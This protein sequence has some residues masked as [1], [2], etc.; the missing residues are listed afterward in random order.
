LAAFFISGWTDK[1]NNKL[2]IA[3][4]ELVG[5]NAAFYL[6]MFLFGTLLPKK[7]RV[8]KEGKETLQELAVVETMD[9]SLRL[10]CFLLSCYFPDA[11]K[12]LTGGSSLVLDVVFM[13]SMSRSR[14]LVEIVSRSS[15][16]IKVR[17]KAHFARP[18]IISLGLAR[19]VM[20]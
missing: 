19:P 3:L 8:I 18:Q 1:F 20:V 6:A 13:I 4:L 5:E 2:L 15:R 10:L 11:K 9:L 17:Y 12:W 16:I 7:D 14:R